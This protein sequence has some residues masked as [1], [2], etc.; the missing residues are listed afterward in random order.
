MS[1]VAGTKPYEDADTEV[2]PKCGATNRVVVVKQDGHNEPEEYDCAACGT[3]L[4]IRR[5]SETPKTSV[6]S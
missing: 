6:I 5:A 3:K 4:G 1:V 2:C